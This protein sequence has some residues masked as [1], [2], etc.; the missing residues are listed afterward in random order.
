MEPL[1]IIDNDFTQG[2]GFTNRTEWL[3]G[4]EIVLLRRVMNVVEYR[5][6]ACICC[7]QVDG[8]IH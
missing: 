7:I 3:Q 8:Q 4:K 6:V 1:V 2:Q 5:I